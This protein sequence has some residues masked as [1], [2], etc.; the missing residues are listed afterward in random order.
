[1]VEGVCDACGVGIDANLVGV[2]GAAGTGAGD[3]GGCQLACGTVGYDEFAAYLGSLAT[4]DT[5]GYDGVDT[6]W[7]IVERNLVGAEVCFADG[8]VL[9]VVAVNFS[10]KFTVTVRELKST[11]PS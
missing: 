10:G 1:M 8:V 6:G 11:L 7:K 4:T 5:L 9:G 2:G 3:G